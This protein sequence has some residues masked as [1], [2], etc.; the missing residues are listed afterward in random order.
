LWLPILIQ[1]SFINILFD[2]YNNLR[3]ICESQLL[4]NSSTSLQTI[5]LKCLSE[6]RSVIT[7]IACIN[8]QNE[9][10]KDEITRINFG[11]T[12]LDY[13]IQRFHYCI[14]IKIQINSTTNHSS[15]S[16]QPSNFCNEINTNEVEEFAVLILRFM[17]ELIILYYTY[18]K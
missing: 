2:T 16:L 17:G 14:Q 9:Y 1:S 12:L 11:N 13:I 8:I 3:T 18:C 4:S 10:F 15:N 6:L 7:S 5:I